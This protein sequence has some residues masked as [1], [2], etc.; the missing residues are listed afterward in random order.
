MGQL[1]EEYSKNLYPQIEEQKV[2]E[3][4]K[5]LY[6]DILPQKFHPQLLAYRSQ[7]ELLLGKEE[8]TDV[9]PKIN[10]KKERQKLK[11]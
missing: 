8:P 1:I 2:K 4:L 9:A 6:H 3:P 10:P 7:L 11:K 5:E